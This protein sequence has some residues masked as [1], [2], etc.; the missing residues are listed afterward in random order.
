MQ[1]DL[2]PLERNILIMGLKTIKPVI[3]E[4]QTKRLVRDAY[5]GILERLKRDEKLSEEIRGNIELRPKIQKPQP[6]P[7]KVIEQAVK[8]IPPSGRY[9]R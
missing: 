4:P 1:I 8:L 2:T 3:H 5:K 7:E 6:E 9:P